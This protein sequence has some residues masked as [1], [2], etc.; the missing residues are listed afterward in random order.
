MKKTIFLFFALFCFARAEQRITLVN[1]TGSLVKFVLYAEDYTFETGK[2]VGPLSTL[3]V[4][5][6]RDSNF[7][8]DVFNYSDGSSLSWAVVSGGYIGGGASQAVSVCYHPTIDD[9]L[10]VVFG[11]VFTVVS[12]SLAWQVL[13]IG[14]GMVVVPLT[15][16]M[17]LRAVR[18]GLASNLPLS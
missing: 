8:F 12:W 1:T 16:A 10:S 11:E 18:R 6:G 2:L 17:A 5:E 9:G 3:T 15:L 7:T 13:A 14:C 4:V